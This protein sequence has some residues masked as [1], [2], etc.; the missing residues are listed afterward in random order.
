MPVIK[1]LFLCLVLIGLDQWGIAN[2]A[3]KKPFGEAVIVEGEVKV[4]RRFKLKSVKAEDD[5]YVK[6]QV[7]TGEASKLEIKVGEKNH[8]H[9]DAN[10]K[11]V[12]IREEKIEDDQEIIIE[13]MAGT[14]RSKLDDLEGQ[15]FSI[16]SPVAV[17]GVRGTDFVTS[18]NPA[19]GA[20]AFALTVISGAV[21]VSGIDEATKA[22][23][24]AMMVQPSHQIRFSAKGEFKEMVRVD[25]KVIKAL[26]ATHRV[27]NEDSKHSGK[28]STKSNN[29]KQDQ[30]SKKDKKKEEQNKNDEK[31]NGKK[32]SKGQSNDK[33][34]DSSQESSE[35]SNTESSDEEQ[36]SKDESSDGSE[37]SSAQESESSDSSEKNASESPADEQSSGASMD[38]N[39]NA[40][41]T[42]DAETQTS[43]DSS[44]TDQVSAAPE[45]PRVDIGSDIGDNVSGDLTDSIDNVG[46]SAISEQVS[47]A[48]QDAIAE[49]VNQT[50]QEVV[51]DQVQEQ[52]NEV[53]QDIQ[54]E[55][56]KLI[57]RPAD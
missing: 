31:K 50:T 26:R 37:N 1:T 28:S 22:L 39:S 16:R 53:I 36:D 19:L 51:N 24:K 18:F 43:T 32:G 34:D 30:K 55:Y 52:V 25:P 3:E 5:L 33:K 21:E 17:A 42:T 23:G 4:R 12:L 20:K 29:K 41:S 46:E 7:R 48:S 38:E 56:L 15:A 44:S 10:T 27:Q 2:A 6:D 49:Q 11:M 45:A 8:I 13:L 40:D 47:S 54:S 35:D 9:I 14:I 57:I